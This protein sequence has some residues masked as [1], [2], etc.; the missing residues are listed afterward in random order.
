MCSH[1]LGKTIGTNKL[2]IT[3]CK[4]KSS[5]L[6]VFSHACSDPGAEQNVCHTVDKNKAFLQRDWFSHETHDHQW[7]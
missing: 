3:S 4:N 6:F 2:F 7:R 1:I 5:L